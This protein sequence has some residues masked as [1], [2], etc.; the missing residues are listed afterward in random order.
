MFIN[1]GTGWNDD[2]TSLNGNSK[3]LFIDPN[4]M[5]FF[6]DVD[7]FSDS[8]EEFLYKP[9]PNETL[10]KSNQK[11]SSNKSFSDDSDSENE[12]AENESNVKYQFTIDLNKLNA[13]MKKK[14]A[15]LLSKLSVNSNDCNLVKDLV[16]S[17]T[18]EIKKAENTEKIETFSFNQTSFDINV[19]PKL[20]ENTYIPKDSFFIDFAASES[21]EITEQ[22][23]INE[24]FDNVQIKVDLNKSSNNEN[25][26]IGE[27][28]VA[29]IR[30]KLGLQS[31]LTSKIIIFC[32]LSY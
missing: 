2:D 23:D 22:S 15:K 16:A 12:L 20:I 11:K 10:N 7:D 17:E 9:E 24:W 31:K 3:T 19:N 14:S 30:K 21:N 4:D 28:V 27:N 26:F 1:N 32:Y 18:I 5:E 25:A 8:D 29:N 6:E 13:D